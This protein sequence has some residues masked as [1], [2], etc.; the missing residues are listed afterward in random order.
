MHFDN[1]KTRITNNLCMRYT[2]KYCLLFF[3]RKVTQTT[4]SCFSL[5]LYIYIYFTLRDLY[6]KKQ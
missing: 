1:R 6:K 4:Y 3:F 5:S 2:L